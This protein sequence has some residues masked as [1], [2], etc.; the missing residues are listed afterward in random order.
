MD[1]LVR[2]LSYIDSRELLHKFQLLEN[3]YAAD[4]YGAED[5]SADYIWLIE[6]I[7]NPLGFLSYKL[8][9]LPD[10]T[11]FVYIVKIYVLEDYRGSD[12]IPIEE[13]RA[14][15]ILLREIERKGINILT[16]ESAC[17]ALDNRYEELGFE[18]IEEI[19]REFGSIIGT[20]DKIMYKHIRVNT[21]E[22]IISQL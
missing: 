15:E 4:W 5:E 17:D 20:V 8:L 13:E 10:K 22:N 6:N 16:L 9:V 21:E 2:E 19:S 11:G 7:V 3:S 18:Y 12:A 1:V 14:S